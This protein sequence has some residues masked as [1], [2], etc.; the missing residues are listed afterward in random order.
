MIPKSCYCLEFS[1]NL[2]KTLNSLIF[3]FYNSNILFSTSKSK[4]EIFKKSKKIFII[5]IV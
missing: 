1:R 5:F 3:V 4:L 2:V